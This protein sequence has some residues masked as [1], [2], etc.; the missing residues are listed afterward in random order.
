MCTK[1]CSKQ[2]TFDKLIVKKTTNIDGPKF[3]DQRTAAI[4]LF[5]KSMAVG[6]QLAYTRN[7]CFGN[8]RTLNVGLCHE[9]M[10]L[11]YTAE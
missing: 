6:P 3:A 7:V 10:L 1:F 11:P 9:L 4:S 5:K 8:K 2:T